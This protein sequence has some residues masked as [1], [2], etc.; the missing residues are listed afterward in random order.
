MGSDFYLKITFF[1]ESSE[2]VK[3]VIA[4]KQ[5]FSFSIKTFI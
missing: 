3:G 1:L 2:R 5:I 4:T